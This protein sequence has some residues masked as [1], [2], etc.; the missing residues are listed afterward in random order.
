MIRQRD[1]TTVCRL[2]SAV[3]KQ[4]SAERVTDAGSGN[5]PFERI[6]GAAALCAD[7]RAARMLHAAVRRVRGVY[8]GVL[9]SRRADGRVRAD[10]GNV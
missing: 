5:E 8:G 9:L 10:D 7:A 4:F 2:L 6:D 3:R 1:E